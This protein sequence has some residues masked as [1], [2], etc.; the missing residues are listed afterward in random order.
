MTTK[1]HRLNDADKVL[2]DQYIKKWRVRLNLQSWRVE[3][4]PRPSTSMA[5]MNIMPED[6]LAVYKVGRNFG[7]TAV[8][9]HSLEQTVVH[10]LLHIMLR[11]YQEAVKSG[12]DEYTMSTE[13]GLI[14][15]LEG[16]L[17]PEVPC[18]DSII[19]NS[20]SPQSSLF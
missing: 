14:T 4:S 13:H 5:E 9:P 17:V 7:A 16:L 20:A 11:E 8:T 18:L 12:S 1:K 10:E 2:F 6:R 19:S 3:K 15:V